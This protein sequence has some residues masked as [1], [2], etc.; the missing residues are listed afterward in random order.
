MTRHPPADTSDR[1]IRNIPD[2]LWRDVK[3]TAAARGETVQQFVVAAL[4]LAVG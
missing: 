3:A 1:R 2:H 4:R